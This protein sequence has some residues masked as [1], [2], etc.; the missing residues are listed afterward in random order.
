MTGLWLAC[1]L[2]AIPLGWLIGEL[3]YDLWRT[4]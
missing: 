4:K 2:F 3:L 1:A